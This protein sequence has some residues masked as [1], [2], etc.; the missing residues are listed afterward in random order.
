MVRWLFLLCVFVRFW[1]CSCSSWFLRLNWV[2][3]DTGRVMIYF[4]CFTL[5]SSTIFWMWDD[6]LLWNDRFG[7]ICVTWVGWPRFYTTLHPSWITYS[8]DWYNQPSKRMILVGCWV[9]FTAFQCFKF[10]GPEVWLPFLRGI[11]CHGFD[12]E[13][14]GLSGGADAGFSWDLAWRIEIK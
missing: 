7:S 9:S 14:P 13:C 4:R 8:Q 5:N 6:K 11:F 12:Y 2:L 3:G 10:Q 1:T